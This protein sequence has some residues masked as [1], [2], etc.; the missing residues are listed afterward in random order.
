MRCEAVHL[1][2]AAD[3]DAELLVVHAL[4]HDLTPRIGSS[5]AAG[6][7][8][9]ALDRADVLGPRQDVHLAVGRLHEVDAP[10]LAVMDVERSAFERGRRQRKVID[11]DHPVTAPRVRADPAVGVH[12]QAHPRAPPGAVRGFDL[13][14]LTATREDG[15][16]RRHGDRSL[17]SADP[18]KCIM[19]DGRLQL[20]LVGEID[21]P[22][23]RAARAALGANVDVGLA[24][25]VRTAM[26]RGIQHLDRIAAPER[27][28]SR[29]RSVARA[30]VRRESCRARTRRAPRGAPRTRRRGRHL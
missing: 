8:R 7:S 17:E 10:G 27:V 20:A 14:D 22:E 11:G 21:V 30:R 5:I 25:H 9:C 15:C 26:G 23:V 28:L 24:P 3:V 16:G 29:C 12:V 1:P 18:L 4:D 19:N 6:P 2:E 13:R